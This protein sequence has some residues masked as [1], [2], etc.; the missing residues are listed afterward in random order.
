MGFG[1]ERL[2]TRTLLVLYKGFGRVFR[3]LDRIERAIMSAQ[4]DITADT[5]AVQKNTAILV[6]VQAAVD[7]LKASDTPVD[8]SDLDNALAGNGAAVAALAADVNVDQTPV[9]PVEATGST[10]DG[11]TPAAS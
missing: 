11:S 1:D 9:A 2:Q 4:D 3:Q 6:D 5:A 10:D 7:A 8:L